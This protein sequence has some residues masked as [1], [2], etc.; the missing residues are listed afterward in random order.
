MRLAKKV[1]NGWIKLGKEI[2]CKVVSPSHVPHEAL[3]FTIVGVLAIWP[4]KELTKWLKA[5]P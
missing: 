3:A 1:P 5:E 4:I 2:G